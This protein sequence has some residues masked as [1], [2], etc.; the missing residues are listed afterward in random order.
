MDRLIDKIEG[1]VRWSK[2]LTDKQIVVKWLSRKFKFKQKY[3]KKE[4]SQI[5]KDYHFFNDRVY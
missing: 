1:L 4:V 3:S 2:R 5:I